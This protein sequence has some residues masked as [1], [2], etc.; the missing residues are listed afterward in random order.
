[1][2]KISVSWDEQ[3]KKKIASV[4]LC[5]ASRGPRGS[6]QCFWLMHEANNENPE[7]LLVSSVKLYGVYMVN[8]TKVTRPFYA[9]L[10]KK[11]Y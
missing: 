11:K 4:L 8:Y 6:H 3:I 9:I 2:F 5:P 7:L 1:M 10:N